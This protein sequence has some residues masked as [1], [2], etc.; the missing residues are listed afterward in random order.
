MLSLEFWDEEQSFPA[1]ASHLLR[2]EWEF[3]SACFAAWAASTAPTF[4]F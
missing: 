1:P 4:D 2:L 3:T